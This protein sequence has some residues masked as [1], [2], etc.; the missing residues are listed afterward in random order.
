MHLWFSLHHILL[1][2]SPILLC[3]LLKGP[4]FLVFNFLGYERAVF[5]LGKDCMLPTWSD[6]CTVSNMVVCTKLPSASSLKRRSLCLLSWSLH[7]D[8]GIFPCCIAVFRQVLESQRK[9]PMTGSNMNTGEQSAL[10]QDYLSFS[11]SSLENICSS[12]YSKHSQLHTP[13]QLILL[14]LFPGSPDLDLPF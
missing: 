2:C 14:A 1:L 7:S 4:E 5:I 11:S 9:L 13:F 6:W 3:A 10:L 12:C 8:V